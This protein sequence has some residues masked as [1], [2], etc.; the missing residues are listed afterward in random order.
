MH[1]KKK[2]KGKWMKI[3]KWNN[4][5]GLW[6]INEVLLETIEE[7]IFKLKKKS[8]SP[9]KIIKIHYLILIFSINYI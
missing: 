3:F 9:Y 6:D 2:K 4:I 5:I 8:L 7:K 1:R